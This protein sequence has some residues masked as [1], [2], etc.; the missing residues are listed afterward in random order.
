MKLEAVERF[1][2][3]DQWDDLDDDARETISQQLAGLPS[4]IETDN[5]HARMFD[6]TALRLQLGLVEGDM[7]AF[8]RHRQRVVE[9]AALLETKTAIPAVNAQLAYLASV[10]ETEF[11]EGQ[12]LPLLEDLRLRVRGL[13]QFLD[14]NTRTLVYAGFQDDVL[15]VGESDAVPVP[16]MTGLQ[17]EKKVA[18][19]LRDHVDDAAIHKLRT[20][21]PL[22]EDDLRQLEA[23]LVAI[24][25]DSGQQLLQ[26]L[27]TRREAP[28]LPYFVR[29]IVGMDRGAAVAAFAEY[30]SDRRLTAQ[31][32]RFVELLIDQLTSRGVVEPGSLYEAPFTSLHAGG[33]D[34]LF[35]GQDRVIDGLFSVLQRLNAGGLAG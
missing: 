12:T 17:F 9:M 31:Q 34:E 25:E 28:T 18:S 29:S 30:L 33:P 7:G 35:A 21:E 27:L 13:V 20:N 4:E 1:Q 11:W 19:Y 32:M 24:G 10:Q 15:S 14:K 2:Q 26:E 23:T 6:L 5:V 3:R 16:K 22:S 8:E